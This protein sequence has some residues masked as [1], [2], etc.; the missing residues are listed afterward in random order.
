MFMI[1][2]S[3]I[4]IFDLV[5]LLSVLFVLLSLLGL[6]IAL[7]MRRWAMLRRLALGLA[8]YVGV[9]AL[10]LIGSGLLTPQHVMAMH[11]VR[12]FDDWCASVEKVERQPAIGD[13]QAQGVFYVVT[14]QVTSRARGISQRA[15][16]AAVYVLDD[17][18]VRHEPSLQGQQA[19]EMAGLAGLPLTSRVDAG[20]SFTSIT[21]FDL[22]SDTEHPALVHTHGTFPGV[23]IIGY[24]QSFL[25][26]PTI[27]PLVE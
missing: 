15:R 2:D 27:V 26:R 1:G 20:G 10:V 11:E 21:V 19:L 16:G 24:D 23:I 22:P 18:G 12:C 4:N 3:P 17:Q 9:Y 13:V 5:F 14:V 7:V 6:L 25:H 8:I